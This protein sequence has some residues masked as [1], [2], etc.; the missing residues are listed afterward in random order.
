MYATVLSSVLGDWA[1][2]PSDL[3]FAHTVPALAHLRNES[4]PSALSLRVGQIPYWLDQELLSIQHSNPDLIV[5]VHHHSELW[6]D[7]TLTKDQMQGE[8]GRAFRNH[9]LPTFNSYDPSLN[10]ICLGTMN[11]GKLR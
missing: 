8:E 7:R 11:R 3:S 6:I 1:L 10:L 9:A 4:T 2:E 5:E